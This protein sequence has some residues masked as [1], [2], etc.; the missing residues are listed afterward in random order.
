MQR[1][2]GSVGGQSTLGSTKKKKSSYF[3]MLIV[4]V[5]VREAFSNSSLS[6]NRDISDAGLAPVALRNSHGA[7]C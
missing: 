3:E 2:T 7:K 5:L 1:H 6:V 4:L